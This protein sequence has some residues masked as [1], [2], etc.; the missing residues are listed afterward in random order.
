[1]STGVGEEETTAVTTQVQASL[2]HQRVALHTVV[3][4][5]DDRIIT[6]TG[7]VLN[8]TAYSKFKYGDR[9]QAGLYADELTEVILESDLAQLYRGTQPLVVSA[10][11]YKRLCTAAQSVADGVLLRLK[12]A[13]YDAAAGRIK[14]ARL[15]EGDYGT[16]SAQERAFWM[17]N[18]GLSLDKELFYGRHVI[19]VDDVRIT[20]SH[21][22][23]IAKLFE[24][25][26]IASLT[27]A[28]VI[29]IDP[30]LAARDTKIE[31]RM[32]HACIKT[33][34]D[35]Y[36]L[37]WEQD[38]YAMNA[39]TVKFVLSRPQD[40]LKLFLEKLT[41]EELRALHVGMMDDGYYAMTAYAEG[42][43]LLTN[44]ILRR[45][46]K[47]TATTDPN[48]P[49]RDEGV[50]WLRWAHTNMPQLLPQEDMLALN[51]THTDALLRDF[52]KRR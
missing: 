32:N 9:E 31:D 47:A 38:Q 26:P 24:T 13:G 23:A 10:S 22:H 17:A 52:N 7:H 25:L 40:M 15:T 12:W 14:R 46:E 3:A 27:S 49:N 30:D 35:L 36:L 51:A 29:E 1:M 5:I 21:E 45:I 43:R 2:L 8:T 39:R 41:G 18:N 19:I 11:A 34:H 6:R 37:M 50:M 16:M 4:E 33:L 42:T 20:G 44:E 28:Y 48:H